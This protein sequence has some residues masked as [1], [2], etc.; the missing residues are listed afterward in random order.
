MPRERSNQVGVWRQVA[1]ACIACGQAGQNGT[2]GHDTDQLLTLALEACGAERS[3]LCRRLGDHY[4]TV[5]AVQRADCEGTKA[6]SSTAL[7][8]FVGHSQAVQLFDRQQLAESPSMRD[9]AL[10]GTLVCRVEPYDDLFLTLELN[11]PATLGSLELTEAAQAF[12]ALL[13]WQLGQ[14]NPP[15]QTKT[16]DDQVPRSMR[17]WL[18]KIAA[19]D[20]PVLIQ[21]ET[22]VGK[23]AVCRAV[24]RWSKRHHGPW[25][26]VNC[27][28]LTESLLDGEL[29]GV[30]RGA[31]TGADQNREGLLMASH[32]GTLFLDEVGEMS[33]GLQSKLLRV[34]QESAV[35][36]VGATDERRVDVRIVA[37]T[38][39]DLGR[40]VACGRFREDLY[41]R[42]STLTA[43]V[44]PLRERVD[45]LPTIVA[46][47]EER[48]RQ[49]IGCGPL[50]WTDDGREALRRQDWPGNIRQLHAVLVRACLRAD[51]RPLTASLLFP[52]AQAHQ[53][54]C[55]TTERKMIET[56]LIRSGKNISATSRQLGWS[57]QKLYRRMEATGI[58][59]P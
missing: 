34:L 16:H 2:N 10:W 42:L 3:W 4:Q 9:R 14:P 50:R 28:A 5:A 58:P 37:A 36:P 54:S 8:R 22:G 53:E 1:R 21:G 23:E 49:E 29:F 55:P 6:P 56:A 39:R 19:C 52:E 35:R 24:H 46:A 41:Y 32:G 43:T 47:V 38:H 30:T 7:S 51:G 44:P 25:V 48:I 18:R 26:A 20:L 11:R 31:Y 40:E 15:R 59:V 27:A 13:G 17:S 12:A 57:R 45:D 33:V